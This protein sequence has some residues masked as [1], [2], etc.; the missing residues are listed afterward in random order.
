M[1]KS[2]PNQ[3]CCFSDHLLHYPIQEFSIFS[4][5]YF[6]LLSGNL[7][8][9]ITTQ[10]QKSL[11][12]QKLFIFML[13]RPKHI[14]IQTHPRVP[15]LLLLCCL[16]QNDF[17]TEQ[18]SMLE[19]SSLLGSSLLNLYEINPYYLNHIFLQLCFM[20]GCSSIIFPLFPP[21]CFQDKPVIHS[22]E[23]GEH[24][25]FSSSFHEPQF[26]NRLLAEFPITAAKSP[27]FTW[28]QPGFL[29]RFQFLAGARCSSLLLHL[30]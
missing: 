17:D 20:G 25:V 13:F 30:Q 1:T 15:S 12:P 24:F 9:F 21:F 10:V 8:S 18:I 7:Q 29:H 5:N 3:F 23:T 16:L 6:S 22:A 27:F 19:T 28:S 26:C 11:F 4:S 2:A 14:H